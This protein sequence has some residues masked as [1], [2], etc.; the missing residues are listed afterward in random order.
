MFHKR[1]ALFDDILDVLSLRAHI[2]QRRS[3][4]FVENFF[5]FVLHTAYYVSLLAPS[6]GYS[7]MYQNLELYD[8]MKGGDYTFAARIQYGDNVKT[9]AVVSFKMGEVPSGLNL[10]EDGNLKLYSVDGAN[11]LIRATGTTEYKFI[12]AALYE[13]TYT[14]DNLPPYVPKEYAAELAACNV[15]DTGCVDRTLINENTTYVSTGFAEYPTS[16]SN[17][18]FTTPADGIFFLFAIRGET[19]GNTIFVAVL[20]PSGEAVAWFNAPAYYPYAVYN[21][22]IPVKRGMK[23]QVSTD[24]SEGT[25]RI[26]D[27]RFYY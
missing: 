16:A 15:A 2:V 9:V 3:Q 12:W 18:V 1:Y 8:K 27:Q 21:L 4:E 7:Q 10:I 23:I 14:A 17:T 20:K 26:C 25:W 5:L 6:D 22:T 13:G 24:A 19:A 11:V